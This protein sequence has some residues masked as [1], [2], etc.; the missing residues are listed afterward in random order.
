MGQLDLRFLPLN[1]SEVFLKD[2]FCVCVFQVNNLSRNWNV[3]P[4]LDL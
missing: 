2:L 1:K 4:D 3:Q